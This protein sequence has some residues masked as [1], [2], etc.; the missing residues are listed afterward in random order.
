MSSPRDPSTGPSSSGREVSELHPLLA[1]QLASIGID[2]DT[3]PPSARAWRAFIERVSASYD[4]L[5][6]S[7]AAQIEQ[8][9]EELAKERAMTSGVLE[10]VAD[11]ILVVNASG[12]IAT[13]N[14]LFLDMWRL[15]PELRSAIA[16]G[17]DDALIT[18]HTT[19]LVANPEPFNQRIQQIY[20]DRSGVATDELQLTDGRSLT[21]YTAPVRTTSGEVRARVWCFRDVTEGRKLEVRRAVVAERMASVGQLVA[22]AAHEINNPLAYIGGNVEVVLDTLQSGEELHMRD[23]VEALEDA[24]TGVERI[25]IIVRDL[26]ALSKLDDDTREPMD[27]RAVLETALQMA[28]NELR[29]RARVVHQLHAVPLVSASAVR[30]TQV[31]LNLLMNAAHAIPDGRASENTVSVTTFTGP[32]GEAAIEIKDTGKGIEHR[33][34]ERIYDPFFTTKPVGS[35]TGLGLT[36]CKGI[37]EK[38]GGSIEV[39]SRAG[40]GTTFTVRLPPST[41]AVAAPARLSAAPVR[42]PLRRTI[43]IID[44]DAQIRRSLQRVLSQHDVTAVS[45]V[46]AAEEMIKTATF[47][48]ILCD[49]MMPDRTG[50]DMHALLTS[51]RPDLLPRVIFMSGGAFTPALSTFLATVENLCLTKPFG[52]EELERAITKVVR[53]TAG[54]SSGQLPTSGNA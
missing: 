35:G 17:C 47:D 31:F 24:R 42:S 8:K 26:G 40:V 21:R 43:L 41:P 4:E 54:S 50:L 23:L 30:L 44:D 48:V 25:K 34:L 3:P 46:T 22:S 7:G 27:I 5:Q 53:A 37:I 39:E 45:S 33:H 2:R 11:G 51:R 29:H 19:T 6:E 36:I 38:L 10:S 28:N 52:R 14:R 20:A 49:V 12:S 18:A 9:D 1:R 16:R 15:P 13:F 32:A